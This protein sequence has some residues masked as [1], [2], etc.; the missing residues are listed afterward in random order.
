MYITLPFLNGVGRH[1]IYF[2]IHFKILKGI[3]IKIF[4]L[5][6]T[7]YRVGSKDLIEFRTTV[8]SYLLQQIF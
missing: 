8:S 1:F 3:I 7:H 6:D 2:L 4:T 5:Y